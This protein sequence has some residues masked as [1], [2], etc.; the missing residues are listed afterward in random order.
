M[1]T[2]TL[3]TLSAAIC[4]AL[5][6]A[7]LACSPYLLLAAPGYWR[8][9]TL[10][11]LLIVSFPAALGVC[12]LVT[13]TGLLRRKPWARVSIQVIA[14]VLILNGLLAIL[15]CTTMN[16]RGAI[17]L[18]HTIAI[19]VGASWLVFFNER[20]TKAVFTPIRQVGA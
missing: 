9:L 12:G 20:Q 8:F 19:L 1:R 14:A 6:L 13:S 15:L 17:W 5:S 2:S 10:G 4:T 16:F 11:Q 3:I 18:V 7:A